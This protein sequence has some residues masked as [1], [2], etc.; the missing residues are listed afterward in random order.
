MSYL[1][2]AEDDPDTLVSSNAMLTAA[3]FYALTDSLTLTAEFDHQ[4][5]KNHDDGEATSNSM[6]LGGIIFF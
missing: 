2:Q 3:L 1:D 5:S 6:A 4:S